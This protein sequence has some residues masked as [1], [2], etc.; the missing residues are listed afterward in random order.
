[1]ENT[2]TVNYSTMGKWE[3]EK[4]IFLQ[5]I[6]VK[7]GMDISGYGK[8]SVNP[9]SGYTYIWLEDY[10][11]TLYMPINCELVKTDVVALWTNPENGNEEEFEL[12]NNT[13]L[14]E[15]LAWVN[16]IEDDNKTND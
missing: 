3:M 11:F 5:S 2:L 14:H 9:N 4:A 6:A 10:N 1:M 16:D 13:T 8:V 7:L 15:I 12:R